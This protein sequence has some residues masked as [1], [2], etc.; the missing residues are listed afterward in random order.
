MLLSKKYS[1]IFLVAVFLL[2]ATVFL[3]HVTLAAEVDTGLTYAEGTGLS[4]SQDIR[5]TIA[6]II[7]IV[8]GFLGIVAV[9]LIMYAGW[10]WMTSEGSEEKIEQAKKI[11]TNAVIGLI[12]ILSAFA[13][14][15]FII[16]SLTGAISGSQ[17]AGSSSGVSSGG[18]AALGSGVINS[19]YPERN[20]TGVPRNT[21]IIITFKEAMDPA[22][23]ISGQSINQQNIK[24]YQTE[25]GAADAVTFPVGATKTEDNKTFVFSPSQYLGSPSEKIWYSVAL[26]KNVKKASGASA[27]AG[28][29]AELAYD[30]M[31]E[32]GT[33]VDNTPP[34][35]DS[36]VPAP[37]STEARN[38]VVQINFS[39]ALDPTAAA[40]ATRNGFANIK[41]M[42]DAAASLIAGNFYISNQYRTVEFLTDSE[43]GINS[44]GQTVYCL[45]ANKRIKVLA[46]AANLLVPGAPLAAYPANGLVDLAGNSLDGNGNGT[47]EGPQAQSGL[48]PY[49]A[50]NQTHGGEGDDYYWLFN[51]NNT[52]DITPPV[53]DQVNPVVG[54]S[55]V[56]LS[57]I[58][59]ATFSKLLMSSSLNSSSINFKSGGAGY[60][61]WITK[62]D[63]FS[64][65]KTTANINHDQFAENQEY[66]VRLNSSIKDIYQNCYTPCS[67]LGVSGNPSCCNGVASNNN[68]CQ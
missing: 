13:I 68:N 11:L 7:R 20:Q 64:A 51:T 24:I 50:N 59:Q 49:N 2:L 15:S 4:A 22:T 6:K 38:V 12:I 48:V 10:I 5:V 33:Y 36:V 26:S 61:Y 57:V 37:A 40:G 27:F 58:P 29:V 65:K 28:A 9:G 8:I 53:V 34:K 23:L 39:E 46:A 25:S 55:G 41:V 43:C 17:P 63:D 14:V 32:V 16:N 30:W 21:K 3:F 1:K 44:C 60:N 45:P 67:G 31:F 42:D 54:G 19:H 35:I 47:A 18:L 56:D 62:N 52:I 66:S